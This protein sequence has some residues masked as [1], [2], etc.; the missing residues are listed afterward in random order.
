[1]PNQVVELIDSQSRVTD[2]GQ[3]YERPAM[4]S[5]IDKYSRLGLDMASVATSLGFT[6]AKVG[7][8]LGVCLHQTLFPLS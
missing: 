4:N 2:C 8:R 3:N 1:M 7:T 6:A 5:Q